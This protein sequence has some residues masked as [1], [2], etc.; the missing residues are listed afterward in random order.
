MFYLQGKNFVPTFYFVFALSFVVDKAKWVQLNSKTLQ[1]LK[2]SLLTGVCHDIYGT[3]GAQY[4][5]FVVKNETKWVFVSQ[6]CRSIWLDFDEEV[7]V[8][9]IEAYRYRPPFSVY[10]MRSPSTH[11]ITF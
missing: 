10:D 5:P 9:G 8:R 11:L 7:D 2:N 1:V 3:D 6:L 4:P